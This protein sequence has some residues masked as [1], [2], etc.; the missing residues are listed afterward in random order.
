VHLLAGVDSSDAA[1]PVGFPK[2]LTGENESLSTPSPELSTPVAPVE[3]RR[4]RAGRHGRRGKLYG[5]AVLLILALVLVVILVAENT[6]RVKVGWI[7]GYSHISLVFLI[8]FATVLGWLLGVATSVVFR[9]RT[10]RPR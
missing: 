8:L 2:R 9:R 3:T 5:W 6:R 7:F 1:L 4:D 10:R